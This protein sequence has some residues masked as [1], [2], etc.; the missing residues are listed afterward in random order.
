MEKIYN[1]YFGYV[2]IVEERPA[3]DGWKLLPDFTA[4]GVHYHLYEKSNYDYNRREHVTEYR[5]VVFSPVETIK[6]SY[7]HGRGHMEI[8]NDAF[9]F[10]KAADLNRLFDIVDKSDDVSKN[11]EAIRAA[12][13]SLT[14]QVKKEGLLSVD[15]NFNG[16]YGSPRKVNKDATLDKL[17]AMV[18]K[19]YGFEAPEVAEEIHLKKADVYTLG[20]DT[21]QNK[22][23]IRVYNG[24]KFF[25]HGLW[26]TAH[27]P[28]QKS[29]TWY[30]S[31]ASCGVRCAECYGK[32][33]IINAVTED[34]VNLIKKDP[35]KIAEAEKQ[36][37]ETME[38]AENIII[39]P[40]PEREP[41]FYGKMDPAAT[42]AATDPAP[43]EVR[44]DPTPEEQEEKRLEKAREEAKADALTR[45]IDIEKLLNSFVSHY[46]L[47]YDGRIP[48]EVERPAVT[49]FD[50]IIDSLRD[51]LR[52]FS[53]CRGDNVTSDR[54]AAAFI[55]A[56]V[57]CG[58]LEA[59]KPAPDPVPEAKEEKP[60]SVPVQMEAKKAR[61]APRLYK[62]RPVYMRIA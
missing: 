20:F 39:T 62:G 9:L 49:R 35:A 14:E 41:V 46:N 8:R 13:L 27:K 44:E 12:L 21:A 33:D 7:N 31:L 51:T 58:Y 34:L 56:M 10:M 18:S 40:G 2:N 30:I 19:R 53:T 3:G 4:D 52:D 1:Q 26:F 25:K 32:N 60:A 54:E 36:F 22:R 59:E 47:L 42:E 11:A 55:L 28:Y 15:P 50:S 23:T 43:E 38:T 29:K 6:I 16:A 24:W 5:A 57:H 61:K 48:E 37:A 17:L 45:G